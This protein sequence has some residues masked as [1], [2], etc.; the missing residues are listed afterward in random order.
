MNAW[1]E[2]V[3]STHGLGIVS[4]AADVL[5]MS[6]VRAMRGVSVVHGV[7]T[8]P[9]KTCGVLAVCLCVWCRWGVGAGLGS[10]SGRVVWCY[11][12]VSC[13]SVFFV[14]M[15]DTYI[16]ILCWADTCAS[17][18]QL[19]CPISISASYGVF[20]CGRYSKSRLVCVYLSDVDLSRHLPLL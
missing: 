12:C 7:W 15:A 17:S 16:C 10:R 6:V 1:H 3:S 9:V 19:C 4:S 11:V 8:N 18:V 13:E 20:V 14:Y 2:Y 5:E